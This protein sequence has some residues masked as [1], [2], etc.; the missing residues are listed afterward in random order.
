[1]RGDRGVLSTMS[2][3]CHSFVSEPASLDSLLQ[4]LAVLYEMLAGRL[5]FDG[6]DVPDILG[7]VLRS[8]PDWNALP[9][10]MPRAIENLLRLCLQKDIKKRRQAIGDVRIEQ[11]LT[12]TP[13]APAAI[14]EKRS[15]AAWIV[16]VAAL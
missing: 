13:L 16:S 5:A 8:E 6:E 15:R 4:R 10:E 9:S 7:A 14:T 12:E 11:A 1:M 2:S 3:D